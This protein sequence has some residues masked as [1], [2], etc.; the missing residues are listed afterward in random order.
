MSYYEDR[1]TSFHCI[2]Y[3]NM[4]RVIHTADNKKETENLK[5]PIVIGRQIGP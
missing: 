3:T 5:K 4:V 2:L 1:K